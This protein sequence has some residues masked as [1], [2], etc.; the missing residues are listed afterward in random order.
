MPEHKT[1]WIGKLS[2][3]HLRKSLNMAHVFL[4]HELHWKRG[5]RDEWP[6]SQ[7]P[8][9]QIKLTVEDITNK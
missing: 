2:Y 9:R 5:S 3:E 6:D 8:P 1:W 7:W 4:D